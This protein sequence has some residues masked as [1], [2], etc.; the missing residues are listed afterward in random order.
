MSFDKYTFAE[1][2]LSTM[3]KKD[4]ILIKKD[5]DILHKETGNCFLR[6]VFK[7]KKEIFDILKSPTSTYL[8]TGLVAVSDFDKEEKIVFDDFYKDF[9]CETELVICFAVEDKFFETFFLKV[10]WE[11]WTKVFYKCT[12]CTKILPCKKCSICKARYCSAECQKNDWK[13]HKLI[14]KK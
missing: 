11:S 13:D 10:K 14:C 12:F 7:S 9:D 6:F 2:L 8:D 4:I 1:D 5:I 3:R